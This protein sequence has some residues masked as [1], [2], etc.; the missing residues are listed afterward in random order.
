MAHAIVTAQPHAL[1]LVPYIPSLALCDLDDEPIQ[2]IEDVIRV[3]SADGGLC[4]SGKLSIASAC[5]SA[6]F[7]IIAA[8]N[9]NNVVHSIYSIG[10]HADVRNVLDHCIKL[11]GKG[12][13]RYTIHAVLSSFLKPRGPLRDLL[14]AYVY[15]D[16][17]HNLGRDSNEL[18]RLVAEYPEEAKEYKRM[19]EDFEYLKG[20]IIGM[21][22]ENK[23]R[24]LLMSPIVHVDKL[25]CQ[26]IVL[27]HAGTDDVV[28][29]TESLVLHEALKANSKTESGLCITPLLNHGD[30]R[31]L[32]FA[33]VPLIFK[34]IST[35]AAFFE[36]D[37]SL[38]TAEK[39]TT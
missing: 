15:D 8:G 22:D 36:P 29:N 5:I 30:Q 24:F 4:P 6:G 34:L 13:T 2:L 10:T 37:Y 14:V 11:E 39:K 18:D 38:I 19:W 20:K 3:I 28:P 27:I 9:V 1:V 32:G 16:H 35:S 33:D 7:S 21:F 12:D 25:K 26:S 23:E 31:A 17:Y